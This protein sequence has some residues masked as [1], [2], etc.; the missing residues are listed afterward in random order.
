MAG[1]RARW[2][3]LRRTMAVLAGRRSSG[4]DAGCHGA[5]SQ[6]PS[7]R[8]GPH[9]YPDPNPKSG[10][11]RGVRTGGCGGEAVGRERRR[12]GRRLG[13]WAWSENRVQRASPRND[14]GGDFRFE[15]IVRRLKP[16]SCFIL[17]T[18]CQP[19]GV[20]NKQTNFATFY[21]EIILFFG[22]ICSHDGE[23]FY[24]REIWMW[25]H[26]EKVANNLFY[27]TILKIRYM[28]SKDSRL[29]CYDHGVA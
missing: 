2:T 22:L 6:P 21:R 9:Q 28:P 4:A 1:W 8:I 17:R 20:T 18:H 10:R 26:Q 7:P 16:V 25:G 23:P 3:P 14:Y 5:C 24:G 19:N 15:A 11:E 27:F 29:F 12:R 13:T